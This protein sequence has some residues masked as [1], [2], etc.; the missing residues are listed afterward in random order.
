MHVILLVT[1]ALIASTGARAA[2]VEAQCGNIALFWNYPPYPAEIFHDDDDNS[3]IAVWTHIYS[4]DLAGKPVPDAFAECYPHTMFE[5][6]DG[7]IDDSGKT[8]IPIPRTVT[9]CMIG[10]AGPHKKARFWCE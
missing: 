1:I 5:L 9:K 3:P 10:W 7:K 4:P 8:V 6:Q 2:I